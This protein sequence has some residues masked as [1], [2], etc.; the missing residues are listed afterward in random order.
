MLTKS[1]KYKVVDVTDPNFLPGSMLHNSFHLNDGVWYYM[2]AWWNS[3]NNWGNNSSGN[4]I[5]YSIGFQT[6]AEAL[7][8]AE[9]WELHEERHYSK[10]HEYSMDWKE[11]SI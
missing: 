7:A 3:S 6:E 1:G 8:A 2:P 4:L 9:D 10:S 5:A 11:V